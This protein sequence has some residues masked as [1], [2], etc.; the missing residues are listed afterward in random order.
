MKYTILLV[1]IIIGCGT[2][3]DSIEPE[4]PFDMAVLHG[5]LSRIELD[6]IK[7][8]E[9]R[10]YEVTLVEP[11]DHVIFYKRIHTVRF[12]LNLWSEW[13]RKSRLDAMLYT[14]TVTRLRVWEDMQFFFCIQEDAY[15]KDDLPLD[16]ETKAEVLKYLDFLVN[17]SMDTEKWIDEKGVQDD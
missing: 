1:L 5:N 9:V 11:G 17:A 14:A 7:D 12:Q 8:L 3:A 6:T 13:L 10:V 2:L 15:L 16:E 4:I